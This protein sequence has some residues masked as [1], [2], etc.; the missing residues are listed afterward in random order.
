MAILT[1]EEAEKMRAFIPSS[2]MFKVWDARDRGGTFITVSDRNLALWQKKYEAYNLKFN[3]LLPRCTEYNNLGIE[4]EKQ[5]NIPLAISTYEENVKPGSYPARHAYDRLL[6]LYRKQK[7]YRNELR[8][9]K[10][11]VSVFKEEKY[12]KRLE[13]IK[14]LLKIQKQ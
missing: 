14:S 4:Y 11:A 10:L 12:K 6:V 8:V 1:I 2:T 7:D 3:V 13:K 5:G 9:C